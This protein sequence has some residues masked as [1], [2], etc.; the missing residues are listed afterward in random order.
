MMS[1]R[2]SRSDASLAFDV[3]HGRVVDFLYLYRRHYSAAFGYA[4]ACLNDRFAA[5]GLTQLA[6][7]SLLQATSSVPPSMRR[8]PGCIRL[9]VLSEVRTMAVDFVMAKRG[10]VV[11]ST[12]FVEW[13]LGGAVWPITDD[14]QLLDAF[15]CLSPPEQQVL[16]HAVVESEDPDVVR[17]ITG[18]NSKQLRSTCRTAVLGL[19][20]EPGPLLQNGHQCSDRQLGTVKY[21]LVEPL[22]SL[23]LGWWPGSPYFERKRNAPVPQTDPAF[24]RDAIRMNCSARSSEAHRDGLSHPQ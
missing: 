13:A 5:D 18:L 9:Q 10:S 1:W 2:S 11:E 3:R 7:K 23:L 24:L 6:F 4:D 14:Q 15:R 16:W 8:H 21:A 20:A 22:P 12:P 17:A 19:L